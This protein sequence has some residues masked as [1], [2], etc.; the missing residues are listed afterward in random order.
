MPP[1]TY[2]AKP[3]A[4]DVYASDSL[5]DQWIVR[6]AIEKCV[7]LVSDFRIYRIAVLQA[8]ETAARLHSR[9]KVGGGQRQA[10]FAGIRLLSIERIGPGAGPGSLARM[11]L[12]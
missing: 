12:N 6:G 11:T 3:A 9:V 8:I 5:A 7:P 4:E 2:S 1:L 10:G